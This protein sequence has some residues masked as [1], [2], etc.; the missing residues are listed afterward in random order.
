[1]SVAS[2]IQAIQEHIGNV[3]DTLDYAIDTTSE[4]KN[5]VNIPKNIYNGYLDILKDNGETLFNNLPKVNG[6]GTEVTLNDTANAPMKMI[7]MASELGQETTTGKN[8]ANDRFEDYA[9]YDRSYAITPIIL[10]QNTKYTLKATLVG[11]QKTSYYNF[12]IVKDGD[13]YTNF[14]GL[15]TC[16]D[17]STGEAKTLSFTIDSEWTNPKLVCY[18]G[19]NDQEAKFNELMSN[20]EI[21][22]EEGS[23]ATDYEPYTN[24]ASPNPDYPQEIHTISGDNEIVVT[25]KNLFDINGNINTW[26]R[27]G[28]TVSV[29]TVIDNNILQTNSNASATDLAGQ[30]FTNLNGKT[31]T[32]TAKLIS[33][34]TGNSGYIVIYDNKKIARPAQVSVGAKKNITYTAQSDD[35][36]VTFG[37]VGG[38]GAQFT[39]IQVELN[40]TAT[41][42]VE[43]QEQTLPLNLGDLEYCKIGDYKDEFVIPSGKSLFNI[44]RALGTPSDTNYA[45]TTKRLFNHNEYIVGISGNNY[46]YPN[47]ITS[48]NVSNSGITIKTLAN[49]YGLGF[50][51]KVEAN[52]VYKLS[53]STSASTNQSTRVSFYSSDGTWLSQIISTST[54][55][56]ID[57]TTPNN[58]DFMVIIFTPP[59]NTEITY[60]NIMLNEGTTALPYEP[61]NP[62]G[63]W[64]L[65]KN[66]GKVVLDINNIG[67]YKGS[68]YSQMISPE[69][70]VDKYWSQTTAYSNRFAYA[71]N[72]N[73]GSFFINS[74]KRINFLVDTSI[75]T[76]EEAKTWLASNNVYAYYILATPTY[77]LLNDTLQTQLNN[78]RDKV[79]AYQDQTNISQVNNDLPFRLKLSAIKKYSE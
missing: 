46:Y 66:I 35:I 58:C 75:T 52:K 32:F 53:Y 55:N 5:I 61:Y 69:L 21:Q 20:Y 42:Y 51:L 38:K 63:K 4:N 16:I 17:Y 43:H 74:T 34:G 70:D 27:T 25:G 14:I 49:A 76:L 10:K 60:S 31:F 11:K 67:F 62:N 68:T 40:S 13:R 24:G 79:L 45:N 44:D 3:Y 6:E 28:E 57:I 36:V 64:Y 7:P 37:T 48:Y 77:T 73:Y 41:D 47:Y 26:A 1:M 54:N 23:T 8:L 50:S 30:K 71:Y 39:D 65:K 15:A 12:G 19:P 59:E 9:Q 72:N 18:L 29:N 22:L 33:S 56:Y 78:I 2:R